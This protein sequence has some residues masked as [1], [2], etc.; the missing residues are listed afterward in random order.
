MSDRWIDFNQSFLVA[1]FSHLKKALGFEGGEVEYPAQ[2]SAE[3]PAIERL[4]QLFGL[5][6]FERHILLLAAGVEMDSTLAEQCRQAQGHPTRSNVTF[7]LAMATLPDP[8]W[9]A[10]TPAGPLRRFRLV[11]LEPGHGLTTAPLRIDERILHYLAGVNLPDTRLQSLV[12]LS[13]RPDWIADVHRA[14]AGQASRIF[15]SEAQPLP[16]LHLC[17]DDAQGQE[18]VAAVTAESGRRQLYTLRAEELP[19]PGPDLDQFALLWERESLLL[20]AALLI[21]CGSGG[22]QASAR[23]LAE[24]LAGIVMLA[25]QE[26]VRVSR[27]LL[28]LDVD[29]PEPA[30]Q[31]FSGK[32]PLAPKRPR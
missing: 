11:E 25:S 6:A 18:D 26:P 7:G 3:P 27:A 12:Q 16:L 20:P 21:Q 14:V 31:K 13:P 2:Q 17:G 4:S 19:A 5:S 10:L 30:A 32:K 24:R 15:H 22:F 1:Q 8:H 28:R 23:H 29:K 9:S